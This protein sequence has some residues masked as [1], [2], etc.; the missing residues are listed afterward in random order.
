MDFEAKNP[1][2]PEDQ[3]EILPSTTQDCVDGITVC[4][5]TLGRIARAYRIRLRELLVHNG[6]SEKSVIR[7]GQKIRI[8]S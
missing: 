1:Q 7:P 4:A 6:L 2:V 8:P 5:Y 3:S